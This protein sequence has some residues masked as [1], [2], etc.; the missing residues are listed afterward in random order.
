MVLQRD[1]HQEIL[2]KLQTRL[3][4]CNPVPG[5]AEPRP[6]GRNSRRRAAACALQDT[7]SR[8]RAD[9]QVRERSRC[10][11]KWTKSIHERLPNEN[12]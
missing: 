3:H 5:M 12:E 11:K 6:N 10:R 2:L 7:N 8:V 1:K 4:Y 9:I